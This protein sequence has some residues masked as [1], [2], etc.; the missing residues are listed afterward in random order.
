VICAAAA[1][2][3][4]VIHRCLFVCGCQHLH[5]EFTK[6]GDGSRTTIN[7]LLQ[8]P[9]GGFQTAK[10]KHAADLRAKGLPYPRRE[11]CGGVGGG[12][13]GRLPLSG[14]AHLATR[15]VLGRGRGIAGARAVVC[16]HVCTAASYRSSCL[17]DVLH[18]HHCNHPIIKPNPA[19]LPQHS[20]SCTLGRRSQ[21]LSGA[22]AAWWRRRRGGGGSRRRRRGGGQPLQPPHAAAAGRWV[23]G[24]C[25]RQ[26]SRHNP[27]S[28]S[29]AGADA[30]MQVSRVCR[31]GAMKT[32][33]LLCNRSHQLVLT[34]TF[35][36]TLSLRLDMHLSLAPGPDGQVPEA[37][38][39]L[40][41][42]ALV[43]QV[44][45]A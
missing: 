16:G 26:P 9:G 32:Q 36:C 23:V 14:P 21:R 27:A 25:R 38:A 43:D 40:G 18:T 2:L 29:L 6:A 13:L 41:D 15:A 34:C 37:V 10:D 42:P 33:P 8:A 28:S 39:K 22:P 19:S 24:N 44:H 20:A 11:A 4:L 5:E 12:N 45:L 30:G 35:T 7:C 17:S 31:Q 1:G 3:Q